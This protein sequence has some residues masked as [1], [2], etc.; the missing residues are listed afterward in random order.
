MGSLTSFELA[1]RGW[2]EPWRA[3]VVWFL[4]PPGEEETEPFQ[5]ALGAEDDFLVLERR[6]SFSVS[7]G[8]K[9]G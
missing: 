2:G 9:Q 8:G 5:P 3:V 4:L 7:P 6:P 1:S